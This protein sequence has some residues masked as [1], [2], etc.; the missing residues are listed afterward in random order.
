MRVS[1]RSLAP[2]RCDVLRGQAPGRASCDP[3]VSPLTSDP[4]D[5][6]AAAWLSTSGNSR[7][8][9]AVTIFNGDKLVSETRFSFEK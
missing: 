9:Y 1:P 6:S 5:A 7:L 8:L 4:G 3:S 2:N